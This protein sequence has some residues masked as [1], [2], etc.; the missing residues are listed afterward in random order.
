[1]RAAFHL[2]SESWE[3]WPCR[4]FSYF[5]ELGLLLGG[6]QGCFPSSKWLLH[7]A[8]H[9]IPGH[10]PDGRGWPHLA[11]QQTEQHLTLFFFLHRDLKPENILLDDHGGWGAAEVAWSGVGSGPPA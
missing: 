8:P 5:L 11:A 2:P 4:P 3:S 9:A 1:M 6:G 7:L 10:K